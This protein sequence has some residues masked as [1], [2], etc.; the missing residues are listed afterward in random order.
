MSELPHQ[1]AKGIH[2]SGLGG[3]PI[4]QDLRGDVE[5]RP[6]TDARHVASQASHHA[7]AKVSN[8]QVEGRKLLPLQVLNLS[9]GQNAT[10]V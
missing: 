1:H 6:M 10:N 2:V 5:R 9:D 7:H 3:L 8:L 4:V